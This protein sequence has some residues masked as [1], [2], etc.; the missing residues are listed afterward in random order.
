MPPPPPPLLLLLLLLPA[1]GALLP[2]CLSTSMIWATY[3][4][5]SPTLTSPDRRQSSC[6]Y[7]AAISVGFRRVLKRARILPTSSG[8]PTVLRVCNRHVRPPHA[9]LAHVQHDLL[10]RPLQVAVRVPGDPGTLRSLPCSTVIRR[11]VRAASKFTDSTC[12]S[13]RPTDRP[14]DRLTEGRRKKTKNR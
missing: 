5:S 6:A 9:A 10:H 2:T 11:S 8:E 1:P 3:V 14:T 4:S 12:C 13:D 7:M